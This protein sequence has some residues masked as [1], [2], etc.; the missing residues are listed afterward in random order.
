MV[1]CRVLYFFRECFTQS[2]HSFTLSLSFETSFLLQL[3]IGRKEGKEV[4]HVPL[5][6]AGVFRIAEGDNF[7]CAT[8]DFAKC[9]AGDLI[10]F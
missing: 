6:T 4:L 10:S 3:L 5:L 8:K 7:N 2:F 9:C 1:I